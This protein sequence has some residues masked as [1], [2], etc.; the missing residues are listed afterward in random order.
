MTADGERMATNAGDWLAR[1]QRLLDLLEPVALAS[2]YVYSLVSSIMGLVFGVVATVQCKL[3][4]NKK[5][6][7]VCIILAL[8]NILLVTLCVVAYVV[9]LVIAFAGLAAAAKPAVGG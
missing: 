6:G 5:V 9:I 7:R 1:E 8:V 4:A 3:P 2:L